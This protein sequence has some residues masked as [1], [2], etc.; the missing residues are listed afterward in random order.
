MKFAQTYSQD[1]RY[2]N[3][4]VYKDFLDFLDIISE[5][6]L[7]SEVVASTVTNFTEA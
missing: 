3:Y 4:K 2:L 7:S 1:K 6:Q 5:Q